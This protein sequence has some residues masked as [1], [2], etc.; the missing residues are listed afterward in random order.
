M[1]TAYIFYDLETTGLSKCFD[2]ITQFAAIRTDEHFNEIERHNIF[3]KLRPDVLYSPGALITSRISVNSP[4]ESISEYEAVKKIHSLLNQP[5]TI[6]LGYNSLRFDDEFLR[7][8]FHRNLLPAYTHQFKN[9]C[10]RMDILP[11]TLMFYLYKNEILNWPETH[12]KPSLKLENINAA[13]KL[14]EGRAH[15]A[16]VDVEAAV[17]LAKVLCLQ[18]EMWQY[19]KDYFSKKTDTERIKALPKFFDQP[20]RKETWGIMPAVNFGADQNFQAPVLYLGDSKPYSNQSL[21]LRL[22][23]PELQQT[24]INEINETTWVIRK[25][26]GEPNF[27]LPPKDRFIHKLNPEQK[28][29]AEENKR[30]LEKNPKIFEK[31][32]EFSQNYEYPF[33]PDLDADAALYQMD[34]PTSDDEKIFKKFHG[35]HMDQKLDI[36]KRIHSAERQR[37][38]VRIICRNFEES[39][40]A[41]FQVKFSSHIKNIYINGDKILD[42]RKKPY[43]NAEQVLAEI[44][45]LKMD[46]ELDQEQTELLDELKVYLNG[47]IGQYL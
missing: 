37:I 45:Q 43:R 38:A 8:A 9:G 29:T 34:F 15:D 7:F 36:I 25:K 26:Y 4:E 33:I 20:G 42:Y 46:T 13:N 3:V 22:D 40:P 31:T 28:K 17:E 47:M 32:I 23:L 19:L 27:V 2:Q 39:A 5:N 16:L 21:W 6:S 10:F 11:M 1:V 24:S 18:K 12:G 14:A 44:E 41:D 35:P 30:W